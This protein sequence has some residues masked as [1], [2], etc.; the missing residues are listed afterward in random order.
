MIPNPIRVA[1]NGNL[2]PVPYLFKESIGGIS[3]FNAL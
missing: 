3:I 2:C 1:W